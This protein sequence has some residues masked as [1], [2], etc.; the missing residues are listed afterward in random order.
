MYGRSPNGFGWKILDNDRQAV[1]MTKEQ[2]PR[3][4]PE[5]TVSHCRKSSCHRADCRQN[6]QYATMHR[7]LA[8]EN[9]QNP[10]SIRQLT[11]DED[12]G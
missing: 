8:G 10:S 5:L 7:C 12:T 1:L 4:L 11:D 2:A 3:G 9:S 6:Q